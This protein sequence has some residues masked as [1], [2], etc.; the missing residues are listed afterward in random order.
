[1]AAWASETATSSADPYRTAVRRGENLIQRTR[2]I[3]LIWLAFAL[4]RT[5]ESRLQPTRQGSA[6]AIVRAS[7]ETLLRRLLFEWIK[8]LQDVREFRVVTQTVK[9]YLWP[10][11]MLKIPTNDGNE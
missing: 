2:Q 7:L 9:C 8:Q 10:F 5:N 3:G 4:R 1:M 11:G 6:P